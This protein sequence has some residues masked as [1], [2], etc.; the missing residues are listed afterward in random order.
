MNIKE[1][2]LNIK[3]NIPDKISILAAIKTRSME[4]I[5][6][7]IVAGIKIIGENYVQEAEK[8]Y[9]ILK[10]SLNSKSSNCYKS[11]IRN[12]VEFHC[13]GHLQKNKVKKAVE[14]FDMIQTIDSEKIAKEVNNRCKNINKIMP[15]LIE[16]NIGKESNKSG[17]MPKDV[18][19]LA[20]SIS[21]L[22]NIK[23]KGLMT[24]APYFKDPEKS[25]PYFKKTKQLFDKMKK[26]FPKIDTL[27]MGMSDSYKIAIEEGATMVR[28]GTIIFG[29]R[30]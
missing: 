4:E 21:K 10:G 27:S 20:E 13:I 28:L 15:V 2:I 25:R 18:S 1:N 6:K 26:K 12:K 7:A 11:L 19:K 23:L 29:E 5:K 22:N 24:M 8:K 3:N 16:V 30:K 9:K 17:C 14:V